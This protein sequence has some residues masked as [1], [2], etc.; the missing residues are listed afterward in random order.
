MQSHYF[1]KVI[2]IE[3]AANGVSYRLLYLLKGFAFGEDGMPK[4]PCF[5]PTIY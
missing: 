2:I 4:S 3:M 1:Q 5:I